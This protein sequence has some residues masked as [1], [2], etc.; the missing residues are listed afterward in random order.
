M[1]SER[2]QRTGRFFSEEIPCPVGPRNCGQFSPH[3]AGPLPATIQITVRS[4][5]LL[6]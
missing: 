1:F 6:M 4:K 5:A 3:A 2:L